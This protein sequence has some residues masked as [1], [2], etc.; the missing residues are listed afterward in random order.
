M[1]IITPGMTFEE[2]SKKAWDLPEEFAGNRYYLSGHGVG[3]TGE[4]PYLYHHQDY[5]EWGYDGVIEP[6]MTLCIESYIGKPGE[7]EGVKLEQQI[8]VTETGTELLS[9]FPFEDGL[10]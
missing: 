5:V 9:H 3:L 1:G 2:Y 6:G 4:Y 8:L 7:S 10:L